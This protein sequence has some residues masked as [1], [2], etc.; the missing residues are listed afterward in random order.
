ML[1]H[2]L[3]ET[4]RFVSRTA[5]TVRMP[6]RELEDSEDSFYEL[7]AD[8]RA[9]FHEQFMSLNLPENSGEPEK[10]SRMY[11]ILKHLNTKAPDTYLMEEEQEIFF[12]MLEQMLAVDLAGEETGSRKLADSLIQEFETYSQA[13]LKQEALAE[14]L[15]TLYNKLRKEGRSKLSEFE[16]SLLLRLLDRFTDKTSEAFKHDNRQIRAENVLELVKEWPGVKKKV[17]PK[18]LEVSKPV[19]L[20]HVLPARDGQQEVLIIFQPDHILVVPNL[21]GRFCDYRYPAYL[22]GL[23]KY[24]ICFGDTAKPNL[25]EMLTPNYPDDTQTILIKEMA[26]HQERQGSKKEYKYLEED[27]AQEL[28]IILKSLI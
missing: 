11:K 10:V 17:W 27:A 22:E 3:P 24:K 5:S 25:E 8:T 6:K 1:D 13:L 12:R 19:L 9:A 20:G 28:P 15:R 18:F 4:E 23:S 14:K 2:R 21:T 26:K 7:T 16:K